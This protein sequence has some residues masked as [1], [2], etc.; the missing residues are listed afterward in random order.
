M[1]EETNNPN[2]ELNFSDIHKIVDS[3]ETDPTNIIIANAFQSTNFNNIVTN[4]R[5]IDKTN[6][7]FSNE[8]SKTT[9][10]IDQESAGLCWI[11]GAMTMCRGSIIKKLQLSDNF[12]LS[13]NYF[14]FWDKLEK[15]N[16]FMDFIIKNRKAKFDS[17]KINNMV[18]HPISDGGHWHTFVDLVN[19]YGLVPESVYRRRVSSKYT[20][21]VNNLL[22]YK[23]REFTAI[24]MSPNVS[25]ESKEQCTND[26]NKELIELN[27]IKNNYIK[28]IVTILVNTLGSPLYPDTVFDWIHEEKSGKNK[29]K[30]IRGLTPLSF[31]KNYC[32]VNF[33]NY[34]SVIND[35]RPRHHFWQT[36]EK[37]STTQMVINNDRSNTSHITLNLPINDIVNLITK[38]VDLGIPIWF[39]C[40]V[41]KYVNHKHNLMDIDLY[42]MGL[43]FN[44]SFTKMTKADRLDFCDSHACHAMTIVGYDTKTDNTDNN[45][46]SKK[47][48]HESNNDSTDNNIVKFK[49]EN[50]WGDIGDQD[51]FYV[52]TLDW[53][54]TFGYEVIINKD[55]L[56]EEQ[57]TAFKKK[58]KK[59]KTNDPLN[60]L[61]TDETCGIVAKA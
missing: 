22:N 50:S 18:S 13:L 2:S 14:L 21:S 7:I 41:T 58:P 5:I 3:H 10:T 6:H 32:D 53:F 11:C 36:Y 8:I 40:D 38:Q 52:M 43:P 29:K 44:T 19:K 45:K 26:E 4:N 51:G 37:T 42:N 9:N 54:T 33:D 31:Y 46:S 60:K 17:E 49:V 15:C 56:T 1:I 47:R 55:L 23:L 34:V 16:Y 28:I 48:K 59:M 12:H 35:P 20:A 61:I 24:V 27:N 39:S 57:K 30:I 25:K